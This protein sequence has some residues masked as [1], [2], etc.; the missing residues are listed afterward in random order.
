MATGAA[1]GQEDNAHRP[2]P[3]T[4]TT[5]GCFPRAVQGSA[6][7]PR[8]ETERQGTSMVWSSSSSD[9]GDWVY[10]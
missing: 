5:K 8:H 6:G 4:G 1:S 7:T 2:V 9:G 10:P 3:Q